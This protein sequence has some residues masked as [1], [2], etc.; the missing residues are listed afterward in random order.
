MSIPRKDNKKFYDPQELIKCYYCGEKFPRAIILSHEDNCE[1][2]EI[3]NMFD[4]LRYD[5]ESESENE[6]RS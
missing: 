1:E 5:L 3:H 2:T 4:S 6:N